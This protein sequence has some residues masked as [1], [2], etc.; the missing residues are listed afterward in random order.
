MRKIVSAAVAAVLLATVPASARTRLSPEQ[1]LARETEGRVAGEP[2]DCV[3]LTN[4]RSSRIID[5]TAIVFDAGN[6]IYVN[7]PRGGA[8]SLDHW[9]VIVTE[10]FG[11][12]LCSV[13]VVRLYDSGSRHLSG[14]VFLGDFVPYKK[15][16]S[17]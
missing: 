15:V 4:L 16:R 8:Q 1:Q 5:K 3:S 9:D 12:Q 6:T 2:R 14:I 13:D 10:P 17:R 7:R 11:S